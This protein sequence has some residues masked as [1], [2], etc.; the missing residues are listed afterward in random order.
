MSVY[1]SCNISFN[2]HTMKCTFF[3]EN[4]SSIVNASWTDRKKAENIPLA[5]MLDFIAE[6]HGISSST[7]LHLGSSLVSFL[8]QSCSD[9]IVLKEKIKLLMFG[10]GNTALE[11]CSCHTLGWSCCKK[12]YNEDENFLVSDIETLQWNYREMLLVCPTTPFLL[13]DTQSWNLIITNFTVSWVSVSNY[14][15]WSTLM[16]S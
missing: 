6:L 11:L 12:S 13:S 9:S 3:P 5:Y 15:S 1:V 7:N 16:Q 8:F 14:C 2:H 10:K 4:Y